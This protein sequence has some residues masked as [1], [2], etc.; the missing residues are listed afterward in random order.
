MCICAR[1][2]IATHCNACQRTATHCN[3]LQRTATHCNALQRTATHCNALQR[4]AAHC[5]ALQRTATH[6]NTRQH[7]A[8]LYS[9]GVFFHTRSHINMCANA[10]GSNPHC[11][12]VLVN[13]VHLFWLG[14]AL[15]P[16]ISF[17]HETSF[18]QMCKCARVHT[19]MH[20]NSRQ[21][22]A[23]Q[24]NTRLHTATHCSK[25]VLFHKKPQINMCAN[26]F[27]SNPHCKYLFLN[28][29]F[30]LRL[31]CQALLQKRPHNLLCL[32]GPALIDGF[33][34]KCCTPEI[35]WIETLK[36]L[37]TNSI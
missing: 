23:T 4:T 21:H 36:F 13:H 30:M 2:H 34:R 6:C 31:C 5:N 9:K 7:T 12:S 19:A 24:G 10:S 37:G 18:K 1:V 25:R 26:A 32:Q 15:L 17:A 29:P 14:V 33:H 22:I 35:H 28:T 8:T 20:C 3:T 16:K 27:G 11:K